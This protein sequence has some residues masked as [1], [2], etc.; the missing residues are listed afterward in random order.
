MLQMVMVIVVRLQFLV[1]LHLLVVVVL[2]E[3]IKDIL[4]QLEQEK[5]V[6]QVEEEVVQVVV[7]YL[8]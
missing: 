1:Q 3:E 8:V 4:V 6:V 7:Q 2:V 5:Q